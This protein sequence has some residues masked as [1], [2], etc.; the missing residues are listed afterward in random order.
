MKR[1]STEWEKIFTN[2]MTDKVL[3]S[4]IYKYFIQPNVIKTSNSNFSRELNRH[5]SN[6]QMKRCSPLLIIR[7][8]QIKTTMRCHLTPVREAVIKKNTNSR[9]WQ[10]CG[11]KETFIYCWWECKL[12]Q[13]LWKTVWR[14]LKKLRFV[15]PDCSTPGYIFKKQK[16]LFKKTHVPQYSSKIFYN[17]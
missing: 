4:N 13:P 7:E 2:D 5:F 17:C 3:I 9:C 8:R 10:G 12:V 11:K 16:H 15:S 6:R 14:F 1:Q